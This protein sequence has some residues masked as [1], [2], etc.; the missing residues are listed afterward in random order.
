M[1]NTLA[2]RIAAAAAALSL[3]L[4]AA[5]PARAEND[6]VDGGGSIM[7]SPTVFLIYWVP[8]GFKLDTSAA[9]GTGNYR[10]LMQRFFTD[11]SGS[12]Y[13]NVL[14]Q[15]PAKCGLAAPPGTCFG[16]VTVGSATTFL[17][18]TPY[19]HAGTSAQPLTDGDVQGAITRFLTGHPSVVPGLNTEFFVFTAAGVQECDGSQ[20]TTTDFCAYHGAFSSSAGPVI[21]SYMPQ[22]DSLGNGCHAGVSHAPNGQIA[23]D[24]EIVVASHEFFES[25]SDPIP[26]SGWNDPTEDDGEIGDKCN[27]NTMGVGNTSGDGRNVTLNGHAYVVQR[28]WSNDSAGCALSLAAISGPTIEYRIVTGG[29]DL[30]G[31]SSATAASRATGGAALQT[32]ML[33]RQTDGSWGNGSVRARVFAFGRPSTSLASVGLTLTSHSGPFETADNWDLSSLV[34]TLRDAV[35]NPLCTTTAT[36]NPLVRLTG[37]APTAAFAT[38]S[39]LPTSTPPPSFDSMTFTI[40]TGGDDLRG[41]SSAAVAVTVNGAT[42]MFS[43]KSQSEPSW[44]NNSTHVKTFTLASPVPL[45]AFG[46]IAITLTSHSGAFESPDNWNIQTLQITVSASGGGST[47]LVNVSGNPFKR[48]TG[49]A[50]TVTVSPGTGC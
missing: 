39:C 31:D 33:K 26:V 17:D 43:L 29:D 40:G 27:A 3:L 34:V 47:C 5:V 44:D 45:S 6:V 41:D 23:T 16:P 38:R 30:R 10:S 50:G 13:F 48:L 4:A 20:C 7:R 35:G 1:K 8:A 15:Y 11:V 25:V 9:G 28:Q 12:S 2:K 32:D 46:P 18:T 49:S 21:Y 14:T 22:V 42:R 36:G 24:R 19:P 37:S